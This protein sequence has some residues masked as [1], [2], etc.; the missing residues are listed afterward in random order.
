VGRERLQRQFRMKPFQTISH[1]IELK[2]REIPIFG[3]AEIRKSAEETGA[4]KL[5]SSDTD[6]INSVFRNCEVIYTN[7]LPTFIL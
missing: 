6:V 1:F 2:H 3:Q 5:A 7:L 4:Y